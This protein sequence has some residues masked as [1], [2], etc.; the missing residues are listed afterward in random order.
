MTFKPNVFPDKDCFSS[1]ELLECWRSQ[2]PSMS[3]STFYRYLH[4]SLEKGV[5]FQTGRNLYCA[6]GK[7]RPKYNHQYSETARDLAKYI[8]KEYPLL[9]FRIFETIQLNEFLNHQ[10][11]RNTIFLSVEDRLGEMLFQ[12]IRQRYNN[13]V[14]LNPSKVIFEQYWL[15]NMIVIQK[16][17]TESPKGENQ[18]WNTDLEKMLVDI[19]ADKLIRSCFSQS[20]YPLI[21]ETAFGR[22]PINESRMFRYAR[23]RSAAQQLRQY[24]ESAKAVVLQDETEFL[25]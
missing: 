4:Q 22:Y 16:L 24:T 12:R 5:I 23:R 11:G 8:E 25:K 13:N 20:E 14:L 15:E 3:L 10:I 21:Y 9:D 17:N 1:E 19:L 2:R 7:T 6:A 18:I